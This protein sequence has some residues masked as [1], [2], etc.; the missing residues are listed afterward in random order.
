MAKET[1]QEVIEKRAVKRALK[2]ANKV[3]KQM[4]F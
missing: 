2:Q 3:A 4:G 1:N